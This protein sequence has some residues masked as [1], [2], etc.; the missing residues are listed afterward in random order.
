MVVPLLLLGMD[1][2]GSWFGRGQTTEL[3]Y[4]L[5]GLVVFVAMVWQ[6]LRRDDLIL[7]RGGATALV[8]FLFLRMVDWFWDAIPDWLFFLLVGGLAFGALLLLRRARERRRMS[9]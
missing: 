3:L 4:Q 5:V 8:L 1:A 6:G 7:A 9:T 2:G